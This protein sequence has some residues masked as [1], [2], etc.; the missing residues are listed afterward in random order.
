M[1]YND[2]RGLLFGVQVARL[3]TLVQAIVVSTHEDCSAIDLAFSPSVKRVTVAMAMVDASPQIHPHTAPTG[4]VSEADL[5]SDVRASDGDLAGTVTSK[6]FGLPGM[7]RAAAPIAQRTTGSLTALSGGAHMSY[8]EQNK[9]ANK[10]L[11]REA[12]PQ[13]NKLFLKRDKDK[14]AAKKANAR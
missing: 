12:A 11:A 1:D 5:G 2:S 4:G 9:S 8:I 6:D 3:D 13:R 7:P 10:K 14:A